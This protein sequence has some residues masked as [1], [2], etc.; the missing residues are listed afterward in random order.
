MT[1]RHWACNLTT[2]EV[3]GCSSVNALKRRI[4]HNE[5]WDIAHG[6]FAKSEWRFYHGSYEGLRHKT[7]G[8][9]YGGV[10]YAKGS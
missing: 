5:A 7:C 4:R 8:R 2:G 10:R 9:A 3:I 1:Q 6:Y